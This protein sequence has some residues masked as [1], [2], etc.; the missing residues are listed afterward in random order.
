M[1]G[2][3][4]LLVLVTL[5]TIDAQGKALDPW[6]YGEADVSQ[7]IYNGDDAELNEYPFMVRIVSENGDHWCGGSLIKPR[8]VL[9]AAH[10][11]V[12][13][14]GQVVK[15]MKVV[16]GDW[17]I[18]QE[19]EN[20]KEYETL[21]SIV[22]PKYIHGGNNVADIALIVL[23]EDVMLGDSVELI[24]LPEDRE[25]YVTGA[26][27]TVI[28][29]GGTEKG[30]ISYTLQELETEISDQDAC[31]VFWEKEQAPISEGMLCTGKP[32]LKGHAWA[33]DS[34]GPLFA[35]D[36][37]GKFVLVALTSWG[38]DKP[39]ADSYDVNTDV[40][41]Y[42]DWI[43]GNTE[44]D[45]SSKWIELKG[46]LSHGIVL[47]HEE[48]KVHTMCNQGIG[49]HEVN[50]IC[51]H[52]GYSYGVLKHSVEYKPKRKNQFELPEYGMT[53][54]ECSSAEAKDVFEDCTLKQYPEE[55]TVPCFEGQQVA[56]QCA[57]SE[58]SFAVD[59]METKVK[60]EGDFVKGRVS[61]EVDA[62]LYGS[63]ID[64]KQAVQVSLVNVMVDDSVEVVEDAMK[65]KKRAQSFYAKLKVQDEIEHHCF[66]CVA[67]L[68]ENKNFFVAKVEVDDCKMDSTA[69]L[70]FVDEWMKSHDG[71]DGQD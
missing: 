53:N 30:Y 23:K 40:H 35:K 66:A 59:V 41:F 7:Q 38:V 31:K 14:D 3:H 29:F 68:K 26:P 39:D 1:G 63:L 44:I 56:V 71:T 50:A 12:H 9:T 37:S 16:V 4:L 15:T 10:C 54:L 47:F 22:H 48:E 46:G 18:D 45:L 11:V 69:A 36:G 33:G 61:C 20:E 67:F 43:E 58:W 42:K 21:R 17:K 49:Q 27:V 5:Q 60:S 32:P 55:A 57:D 28:G 62:R 65:Y 6:G 51:R 24:A 8:V 13:D 25:F 64:M 2:I 34:G 52:L 19:E 70:G